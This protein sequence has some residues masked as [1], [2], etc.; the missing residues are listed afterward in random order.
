[1]LQPGDKFPQLTLPLMRGGEIAIPGDFGP[2]WAYVAFYR[3]H[4]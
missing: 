2:S 3:G 1:M 4:W